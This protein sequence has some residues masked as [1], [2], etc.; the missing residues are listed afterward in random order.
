M[1]KAF[2]VTENTPDY[3]VIHLYLNQGAAKKKLA[4]LEKAQK[5][6]PNFDDDEVGF[7]LNDFNLTDGTAYGHKSEGSVEYGDAPERLFGERKED[8]EEYSEW[9]AVV[10]LAK[11]K[12]VQIY[13][14]SAIEVTPA[15][16]SVFIYEADEISEHVKQNKTIM[17]HV[18][19]FEA[20]TSTLNEEFDKPNTD[21]FDLESSGDDGIKGDSAH[22]KWA[23]VFKFL[24]VQSISDIL[25]QPY[26]TSDMV[27]GDPKFA[28]AATAWFDG[29]DFKIVKK[30]TLKE[31]GDED[32][33]GDVDVEFWQHKESK[34]K[35]VSHSDEYRYSGYLISSDDNS[36]WEDLILNGVNKN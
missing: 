8:A 9:G 7:E 27:S 35:I 24:G 2:A 17:K 23:P 32:P 15:K 13:V 20:F 3:G 30:L 18:K 36:D 6:N 1:A 26:V 31:Y 5:E 4:E 10:D 34:L 19:L 12:Y 33:H 16:A 25:W 22:N 21:T 11:H 29:Q 28:E 14:G